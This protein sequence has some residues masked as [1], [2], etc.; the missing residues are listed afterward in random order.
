VSLRFDMGNW[1][2][3]RTE[4]VGDPPRTIYRWTIPEPPPVQ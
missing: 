1:E 4:R 3:E 2:A